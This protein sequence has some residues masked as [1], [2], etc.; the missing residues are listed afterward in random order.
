MLDE[1]GFNHIPEI[2]AGN[3]AIQNYLLKHKLKGRTTITIRQIRD[4]LRNR[5]QFDGVKN[6]QTKINRVL[7]EMEEKGQLTID[8]QTITLNKPTQ[9]AHP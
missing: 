9:E 4:T 2:T 1:Y 3:V 5:K 6:I 8:R 7:E